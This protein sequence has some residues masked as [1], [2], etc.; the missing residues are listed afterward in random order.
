MSPL[1]VGEG[2]FCVECMFLHCWYKFTF[3]VSIFFSSG[4]ESEKRQRNLRL[5]QGNAFKLLV[6]NICRAIDSFIFIES[7]A[8]GQG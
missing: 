6:R 8:H 4:V 7:C 2:R 1:L 3:D 5:W